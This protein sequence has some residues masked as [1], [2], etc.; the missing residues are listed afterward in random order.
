VSFGIISL[1]TNKYQLLH[2]SSAPVFFNLFKVAEP[3]ENFLLLFLAFSWNPATRN[4]V[5][6]H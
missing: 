4:P 5:E 2:R 1:G 3:F 6:K